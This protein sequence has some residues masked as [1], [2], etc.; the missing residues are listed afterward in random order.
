MEAPISIN[1]GNGKD[2]RK[3]YISIHQQ[4][5]KLNE[6][7]TKPNGNIVKSVGKAFVHFRQLKCIG[8]FKSIL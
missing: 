5:K 8:A 1:D 7:A 6:I 3:Y 2:S 4:L